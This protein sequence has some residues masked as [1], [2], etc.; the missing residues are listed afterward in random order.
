[1]EMFLDQ[2]ELKELTGKT[3][4][5]AI[6]NALNFMGVDHKVRPDGSVA[7]AKA[8]V[9]KAFGVTVNSKTTGRRIEPNWG[10]LK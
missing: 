5:D 9:E 10:N 4:N 8:F 6:I 2:I 3:H 7:V 1:M